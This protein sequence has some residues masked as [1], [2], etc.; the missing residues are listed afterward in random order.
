MSAQ[1]LSDECA[2]LGHPIPRSVLANL[3]NGYR[4]SIDSTELD[5]LAAALRVP[6]VLLEYPIGH[7]ETVEVLPGVEVPPWDAVQWAMGIRE[8]HGIAHWSASAVEVI[9]TFQL[10]QQQVSDALAVRRDVREDQ[11]RFEEDPRH[12]TADFVPD[13]EQQARVR[14]ADF[15][16]WFVRKHIRNCDLIPPELPPELA[17]ID[18]PNF[19]PPQITEPPLEVRE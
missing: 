16:V 3:E 1:Q 8:L 10:H 18:G 9:R 14:R 19:H 7:V 2:R 6:K 13:E 15:A 11:R 5:V 17:H 4:E 12:I